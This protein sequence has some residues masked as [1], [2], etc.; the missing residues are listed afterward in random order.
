LVVV[1]VEIFGGESLAAPWAL[2]ATPLQHLQP[3]A[4]VQF[5]QGTLVFGCSGALGLQG[6]ALAQN[7]LGNSTMFLVRPADTPIRRT[8]LRRYRAL[9]VSF[10]PQRLPFFIDAV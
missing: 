6:G 2:Q 5:R 9:W 3:A 7:V 8:P 10:P 4:R 1:R